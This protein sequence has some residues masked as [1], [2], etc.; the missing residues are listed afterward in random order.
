MQECSICNGW[1]VTTVQCPRCEK[2]M[3]DQGRVTDFLDDYSPYLDIKWTN[4]VDGDLFSSI[5]ESCAHLF[6][7]E[8]CGFQDVRTS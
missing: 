7:C 8:S 6:M 4:L 3:H 2:T 1:G 5:N